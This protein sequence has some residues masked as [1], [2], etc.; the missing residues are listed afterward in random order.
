MIKALVLQAWHSLSDR[1]LEEALRVRMDFMV[2]TN[3]IDAPDH[4][5]ICRFRNFLIQKNLLP[6][7]LEIINADLA[8]KGLKVEK[9]VGAI[10]DA[11]LIESGGRAKKVREIFE[12][13]AEEASVHV[14]ETYSKDSDARWIKKGGKSTFGYKSFTV[15]DQEDGYIAQVHVTPDNEAECKQLE[16]ILN[17]APKRY[18]SLQAYQLSANATLLKSFGIKNSIMKKA[19]RNKPMSPWQKL[20]NKLISKTRYKVEQGFGTLKRRFN[21]RK[22]SYVGTYKVEGPD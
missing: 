4:T 3:L 17:K 16:T 19:Y 1:E 21:F 6:K 15:V 13:R 10:V 20:F 18:A 22:A 2:V 9:S 11:T 14:T 12:D 7:I 5:T 8:M